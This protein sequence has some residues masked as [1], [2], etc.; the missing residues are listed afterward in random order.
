MEQQVICI[1]CGCL[2]DKDTAGRIFKTGFISRN[3]S[4]YIMG[5]CKKDIDSGGFREW[6]PEREY[7]EE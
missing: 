3:G 6:I 4:T 7:S 1:K 2:M 5:I